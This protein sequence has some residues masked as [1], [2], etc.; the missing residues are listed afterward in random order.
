MFENC[1]T[2]VELNIAR[3]KLTVSDES[4]VEVNNAYN[5]RR[6]E[7]LAKPKNYKQISLIPLQ[8]SEPQMF[9]GI[10]YAG[11]SPKAGY[12]SLTEKGFL[13]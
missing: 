3:S 9:V 13:A 12:I 5:K 2:L 6:R 7:I 11:E 10:P 4:I 1:N 8:V